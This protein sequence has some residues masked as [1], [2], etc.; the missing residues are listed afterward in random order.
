[1]ENESCAKSF[2][3]PFPA[4]TVV[5]NSL[6]RERPLHFVLPPIAFPVHLLHLERA[7]VDP[8]DGP[9]VDGQFPLHER[10][11]AEG[12]VEPVHDL[13]AAGR[14]EGVFGCFAAELVDG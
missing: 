9:H 2:E 5:K 14:A 10:D 4:S 8:V 3:S 12:V 6:T 7:Q 11:G 13:D 1:M